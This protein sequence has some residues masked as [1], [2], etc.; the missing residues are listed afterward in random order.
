MG[1]KKAPRILELS[2]VTWRILGLLEVGS[3]WRTLYEK[4]SPGIEHGFRLQRHTG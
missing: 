4:R 2:S 3:R 1:G